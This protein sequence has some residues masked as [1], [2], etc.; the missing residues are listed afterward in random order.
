MEKHTNIIFLDIDG[1]LNCELFYREHYWHTVLLHK[2]PLY[3]QV[4]KLLR[5][6]AKK[7]EIN[8]TQ[9]YKSQICS[10][11]IALLN[12]LCNQTKSAV[13]ISSTWRLGKTIEELQATLNN[14]GATFTIIGKTE[15]LGYERGIEISKWL[16][17]FTDQ[18]FKVPYYDFKRYVIIDDD[19]DM[20]LDQAPH[21]F[22]TDPYCGLTPTTCYKIKYFLTGKTFDKV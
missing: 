17:D 16:R 13:V 18:L 8:W 21:F 4:K 12:E 7:K 6:L 5:K 10:N 15:Y 3:K 2:I 1:V 20:L 22:R 19:A 14:S 11:R 9:Y